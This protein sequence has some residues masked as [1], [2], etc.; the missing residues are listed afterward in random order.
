MSNKKQNN[1]KFIVKFTITGFITGLV[2]PVLGWSFYLFSGKY[3]FTVIDIKTMHINNP[4]YFIIDITPVIIG[5]TSFI[6][7]NKIIRERSD[8]IDKINIQKNTI[9][10]YENFAKQIGKEEIISEESIIDKNSQ[11][12]ETLLL[13]KWNFIK[14]QKIEEELN[15][16][17]TGKEKI[18]EVLRKHNEINDLIKDILINL[19]EY[20]DSVQ[21]AFFLF[22]EDEN[23]LINTFS[24]AY[25]REK[26][27]N[28]KFNI[29]EGIIGQAAYER[30]YIY[31][32][33]LPD[34]YITILSGLL[35]EQKPG[36]LI[37]L[38]LIGDEKIQ[39]V[40]EIAGLKNEY[41][42]KIITFLSEL[43][44]IIKS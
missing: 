23:K 35:G 28:Q 32:K 31:R 17:T 24:Y 29:G 2:F 26:Y 12:D 42:G 37:I 36:A 13:M 7:A 1:T 16:I 22:N 9:K 14:K 6:L 27:N 8:L 10:Q 30:E 43:K 4:L 44:E 41:S 21:G 40:I 5:I 15:W 34:D 11:I 33:N 18:A 38:P 39:G 19:I 20:T 3:A 25:G